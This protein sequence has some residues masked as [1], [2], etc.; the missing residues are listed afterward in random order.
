SAPHA[1]LSVVPFLKSGSL[2]AD[3]S[4]KYFSFLPSIQSNDKDDREGMPEIIS[5]DYPEF[6]RDGTRILSYTRSNRRV[7]VWDARTGYL[8]TSVKVHRK[9]PAFA[10][11]APDGSRFVSGSRDGTICLWN[12]ETGDLL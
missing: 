10:T 6:S 12:S 3:E 1:Y 4:V 7:R 11:F 2:L 9:H 8:L 5:I